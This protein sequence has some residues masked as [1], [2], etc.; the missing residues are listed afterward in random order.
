[1]TKKTKTIM[2]FA[3]VLR[4]LIPE[5]VYGRLYKKGER[6]WQLV[7]SYFTVK[8]TDIFYNASAMK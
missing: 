8:S 7:A 6:D 3:T 4:G 2:S 1:M 5:N